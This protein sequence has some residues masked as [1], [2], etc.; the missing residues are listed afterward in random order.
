ME[1]EEGRGGREEPGRGGRKR[2]LRWA[3]A[4]SKGYVISRTISP[5]AFTLYSEFSLQPA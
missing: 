1:G 4:Y 5:K 2:G 3:I